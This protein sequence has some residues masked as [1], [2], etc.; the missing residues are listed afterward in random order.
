MNWLDRVTADTAVSPRARQVAG[1][2]AERFVAAH[3]NYASFYDVDIGAFLDLSSGDIRGLRYQLQNAGYLHPL[4][5]GNCKPAYQ[6]RFGRPIEAD[7]D[8]DEAA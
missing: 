5:S 8:G 3:S 6:L 7:N 1:V 4:E 2:I